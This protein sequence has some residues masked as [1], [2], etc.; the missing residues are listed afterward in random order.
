MFKDESR[1]CMA[2]TCKRCG[3]HIM[4]GDYCSLCKK[5]VN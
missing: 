3:A 4:Y 5:G 1:G 2:G